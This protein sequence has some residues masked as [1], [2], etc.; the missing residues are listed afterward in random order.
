MLE[1]S[2]NEPNAGDFNITVT[3]NVSP[4]SDTV[5]D[6]IDNVAMWCRISLVN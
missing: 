1:V 2:E 6:T 4:I 3:L 5:V